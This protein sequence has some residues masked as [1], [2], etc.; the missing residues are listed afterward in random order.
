MPITISNATQY[1]RYLVLISEVASSCPKLC[2]FTC[3]GFESYHFLSSHQLWASFLLVANG[4]NIHCS[5][6]VS[7]LRPRVGT[8]GFCLVPLSRSTYS[9]I[10]FITSSGNSPL[11][12]QEAELSIL[13][14]EKCNEVLKDKMES[15]L[16]V[17]KKGV[18]CGTSSRG[19]DSCQVSSWALCYLCILVVLPE[20]PHPQIVGSV[21]S[22]SFFI[23]SP[24]RGFKETSHQ[25]SAKQAWS[26]P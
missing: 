24:I 10:I 9:W 22:G 19:K 26:D 4:D 11:L 2:F 15:R 12:L 5:K 14:Y 8:R 13:R 1:G 20:F 25:V 3:L 16:D 21:L 18:V 23:H 6:R 7:L 17:V